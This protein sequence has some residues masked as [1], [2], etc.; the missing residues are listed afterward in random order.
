M[1]DEDAE[2]R[3]SAIRLSDGLLKKGNLSI[4]THLEKLK[5]DSDINVVNQLALSLR[6]SSDERATKILNEISE[7]YKDNEIIAV[8]VKESLKK[9]D[10][11]LT[12]LKQKI[13]KLPSQYKKR[14][15]DGY[16]TYKQLC[17]T[18]HGVD[19]MGAK[20]ED[21]SLIAPPLIGSA[22]VKGDKKV[23]VKILLNGL[24]GPID[25]KDYGIMMSVGNNSDQWIADVASYI[26]G[27]NDDSTLHRNEVRNVR[28]DNDKEGYWT[29]KELEK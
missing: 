21:G 8:S 16:D 25:G 11:E 14:I 27:M 4:L 19:L 29:L 5:D 17:I 28:R 20:T 10:S 2:V 12:R 18:C 26:R 1:N 3:I 22:R 24:I 6:N 15:M 23:L 13:S 9:D 7:K